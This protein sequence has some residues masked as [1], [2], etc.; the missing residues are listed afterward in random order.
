MAIISS[1]AG[2]PDAREVPRRKLT[3]I[4]VVGTLVAAGTL[5]AIPAAEAGIT[6]IV[7]DCARSQSPT[8][9]PGQSATFGGMSFGAVGQYEKLRGTASGELD[10]ADPRNAIITDIELCRRTAIPR[11]QWQSRVLDGYLHPQADQSWQR[12]PSG[13]A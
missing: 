2:L 4:A 9:C 7:I 6:S 8:F 12:Q 1:R 5:L 13:A 11:P 3:Y 10:H